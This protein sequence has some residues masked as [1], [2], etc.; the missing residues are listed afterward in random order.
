MEYKTTLDYTTCKTCK[1]LGLAI[2]YYKEAIPSRKKQQKNLSNPDP[3]L[4]EM[5]KKSLQK[6]IDEHE[7]FL[8]TFLSAY[9]EALGVEYGSEQT[10]DILKEEMQSFLRATLYSRGIETVEYADIESRKGWVRLFWK[11]IVE[12]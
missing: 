2:N 4:V 8:Q 3:A 7:H 12:N 1:A 5:A 9:K 11:E 10:C 6:D